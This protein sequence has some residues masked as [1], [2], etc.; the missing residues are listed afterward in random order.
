M[1][2]CHI[3]FHVELGMALV[4]KFGEDEEMPPVPKDFPQC[5]NYMY[6][7][8]LPSKTTSFLPTW[9]K[10]LFTTSNASS[11]TTGISFWTC[12]FLAILTL[13]VQK[14]LNS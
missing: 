3:E 5:G 10:E 12:F 7:A 8:I 2:H 14:K 13:L 1:F 9:L 6:D 4:F 11:N